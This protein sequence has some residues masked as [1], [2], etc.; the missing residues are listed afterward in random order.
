PANGIAPGTL[1][2]KLPEDWVC[3]ECSEPK[4]NFEKA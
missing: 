3:P 1:F 4:A 2:E